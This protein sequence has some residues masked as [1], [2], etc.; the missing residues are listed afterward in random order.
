[1]AKATSVW[2]CPE[3]ESAVEYQGYS[4]SI[5]NNKHNF[6]TQ[7]CVF[8][9]SYVILVQFRNTMQLH[10]KDK[11]TCVFCFN[12]KDKVQMYLLVEFSVGQTTTE[13][14]WNDGWPD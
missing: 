5:S 8:E 9:I 14:D 4:T 10:N 13:V 12:A 6:P 2:C 7:I 3:V 11:K 1:M